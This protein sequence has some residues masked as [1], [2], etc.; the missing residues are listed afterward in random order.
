MIGNIVKFQEECGIAD[1][2]LPGTMMT[3]SFPQ[4]QDVQTMIERVFPME[5]RER[6]AVDHT[7]FEAMIKL[8]RC[9]VDCVGYDRA[10]KVR[11]LGA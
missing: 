7:C 8:L 4:R 10:E 11:A 6:G 9:V 2:G 3:K 1:E 5:E